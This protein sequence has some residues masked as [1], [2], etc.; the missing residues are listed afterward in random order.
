MEFTTHNVLDS[1]FDLSLQHCLG[2]HLLLVKT[3]PTKLLQSGE[4]KTRIGNQQ[5]NSIKFVQF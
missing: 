2:G 4:Q 3:K 1:E 5:T